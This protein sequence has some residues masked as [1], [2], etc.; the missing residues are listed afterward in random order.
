[1]NKS[2][3]VTPSI[4]FVDDLLEE[5]NKGGLQVPAFQRAYVW[6]QSNIIELFD[7]IY[8]GFPIGSVLLWETNSKI[9]THDNFGLDINDKPDNFQYILDGQQRITTL[10]HCL[11]C[12][13][14]DHKWKVYIDLE[15]ESFL[16]LNKNEP[17]KPTYFP[18]SKII[19]TMDFI[20]Q[21]SKLLEETNDE[22]YVQKAEIL[23]NRIRKYKLA[24]INLK[25]GGIDDAVEIFTRLNKTGMP[26]IPIELITALN[27]NNDDISSFEHT[28][29]T[30]SKI[31]S[32]YNFL[33]DE[34][35]E[36]SF[37][38]I[39]VR[40]IRISLGFELYSK[41]DTEKV[42]ELVR[43]NSFVSISNKICE[44]YERTVDYLVNDLKFLSISELPYSSLFYM[45]YHFFFKDNNDLNKLKHVIYVGSINGLFN[46][47]PSGAQRLIEFFGSNFDN[48]ILTKKLEKNLDVELIDNYIQEINIFNAKSALG[49]VTF[50]IIANHCI[51]INKDIK[52]KLKY[53]PKT[54]LP[55]NSH[56]NKLGNKI[57][58]ESY[59]SEKSSRLFFQ[60][61]YDNLT[62]NDILIDERERV[63]ISL[64][65]DFIN[66]VIQGKVINI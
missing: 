57:F 24:T 48:N 14:D 38:D 54:L 12:D 58:F 47:S 45:V 6:Q 56:K 53:P 21:S 37:G 18:L 32:E 3:T 30:I 2:T 51:N 9:K 42:A 28:K 66:S 60:D 35:D 50:N 4:L 49:K 44:T 31:S 5:V 40:L 36:S 7:S 10:Y 15:K 20:K 65:V 59:E 29:D 52:S 8:K 41:N 11:K 23:A 13:D 43:S 1:M 55:D 27:F 46:V 22:S 63:I 26:I 61:F 64:V 25:G 33:P 17:I 39:V 62:T 16:Y 34:K 19:K